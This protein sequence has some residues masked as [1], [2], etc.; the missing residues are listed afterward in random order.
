[1]CVHRSEEAGGRGLL[2]GGND[3]NREPWS[4]VEHG[5]ESLTSIKWL[6]FRWGRIPILF[7]PPCSQLRDPLTL[8]QKF[9]LRLD[10][11]NIIRIILIKAF[12]SIL[13]Y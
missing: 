12:L 13:T 7:Y 10:K 8:F 5:S 9:S 6:L 2:A 3:P 11:R 4:R 1:M